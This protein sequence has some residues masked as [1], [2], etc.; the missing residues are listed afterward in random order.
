M[1][2]IIIE[3]QENT[4]KFTFTKIPTTLEELKSLDENNFKIPEYACAMFV[5]I[6]TNFDKNKEETY[7]MIDYI[8]GPN[9]VSVYQ[10][11]FLD[12]RLQDKQYKVNSYFEGATPENNYTPST[13]YTTYVKSTIYTDDSEGYKRFWMKSS[14]SDHDRPIT[15]RHKPSLDHWYL[16]DEALLSDIR[17][18]NNENEWS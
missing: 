6:L 9:E 16:N 11:Q 18:P 13:P 4:T 15:V 17:I 10:K 3:K 7:K 2:N 5:A 14:G 1:E 8:N 12:E